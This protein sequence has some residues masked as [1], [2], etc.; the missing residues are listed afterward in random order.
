MAALSALVFSLSW[1]LGLYL[2]GR[3]PRKPVLA[4]AA[5]G[6][7]SFATAVA[8]DAVRLVT[9]SEL[10]SHVEIYLVAVPGI[11]WFAVLLELA[12]PPSVSRSDSSGPSA[13]LGLRHVAVKVHQQDLLLTRGQFAPVGCHRVHVEH[14]L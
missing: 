13:D 8:L 9:H 12:G 11:A 5:I 4:L 7:C 1:W 6:L 14:V 3:G 2:L 10:L